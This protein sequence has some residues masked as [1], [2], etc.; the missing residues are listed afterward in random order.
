MY[1]K[2]INL[3]SGCKVGL[4]P[5]LISKWLRWVTFK[6]LSLKK[7]KKLPTGFFS[8]EVTCS[9]T[10]PFLSMI[11]RGF[12]AEIQPKCTDNHVQTGISS[13]KGQTQFQVSF[14]KSQRSGKGG[15]RWEKDRRVIGY[16]A[17]RRGKW[18]VPSETQGVIEPGQ[19]DVKRK[20]AKQM[21]GLL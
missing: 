2:T 16:A 17:T 6:E 7:P 1:S 19:E 4:K 13:T 15:S 10:N 12:S 14:R 18:L 5:R 11:F 9:D 8:E 20:K 21:E 3:E